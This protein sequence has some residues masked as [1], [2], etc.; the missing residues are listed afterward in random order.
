MMPR[1]IK[2]TLSLYEGEVAI[3]IRPGNK[4]GSFTCG[5]HNETEPSDD[6]FFKFAVGLAELLLNSPKEVYALGEKSLLRS[7]KNARETDNS[8]P[9]ELLVVAEEQ[10]EGAPTDAT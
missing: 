6:G 2:Q 1:K 10:Q 3:I 8:D 5:I 4:E 7:A 9:D